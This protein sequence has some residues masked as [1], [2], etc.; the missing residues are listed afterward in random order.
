MWKE[1]VEPFTEAQIALVTSF[2]S[3]A[4]IAIEN[5]RLFAELQASA[6]ALREAKEAA[7]AAQRKAQLASQSKSEFLANMSHEIRT[8]INAI[9]GYTTLALR[10]GLDAKQTGYLQT[11]QA[12]GQALLRV[13]DDLLDFSKIEAG[14]LEIEHVDFD[15]ADVVRNV[16][17]LVG[18]S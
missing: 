11:I 10:T 9:T 3:Q 5:A 16:A 18:P 12:A 1:R 15:L 7:E 8:P 4:S 13:V 2:S 6:A 17:A 14:R